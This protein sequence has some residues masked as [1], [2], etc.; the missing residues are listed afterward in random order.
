MNLRIHHLFLIA[1]ATG[2]TL[3][4]SFGGESLPGKIDLTG[5]G[6]STPNVRKTPASFKREQTPPT[7]PRL[8]GCVTCHSK[9]EPMHRYGAT[10]TLEQLKDGKDAVGLTC[11]TCHGGNPVP[12]KTSDDPKEIERVKN[13]AHVRARFPNEWKRDGKSTGANPERTNTLLVRESW[14]FVRFINPGD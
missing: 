11:T 7:T 4:I 6:P 12:R 1:I 13:E 5:V 9:I 3:A 8:E 2:L 10:E 14:E